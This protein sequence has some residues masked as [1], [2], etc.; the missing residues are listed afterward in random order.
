MCN[1]PACRPKELPLKL[2][3]QKSEIREEEFNKE[4][5]KKTI[6]RMDW[7]HLVETAK[8]FGETSL[9]L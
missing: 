5:V 3:V 7:P 8:G 1:L 6:L 9:P 4:L 2:V